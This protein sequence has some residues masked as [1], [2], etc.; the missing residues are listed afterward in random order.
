MFYIHSPFNS[1]HLLSP[2][3]FHTVHAMIC[4]S[5]LHFRFQSLQCN[6]VRA[7]S[8]FLIS[9]S[10]F[11]GISCSVSICCWSGSR[12][13]LTWMSSCSFRRMSSRS[14]SSWSRRQHKTVL[15]SKLQNSS[16]KPG[17]KNLVELCRVR[18]VYPRIRW[19]SVTCRLMSC[20]CIRSNACSL[21]VSLSLS[22]SFS[23][24]LSLS[25]LSL[26]WPSNTTPKH[27]KWPK[28]GF[29]RKKFSPKHPRRHEA[30][31]AT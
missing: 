14:F 10:R 22:L 8:P 2:C 25:R 11:G 3:C 26:C 7:H 24:S 15:K 27:Q 21:S 16:Y 5:I 31:E 20:I 12:H 19:P 6:H 23:L 28:M 30:Q 4:V 9:Y 29:P 18:G 13:S 1:V 17:L